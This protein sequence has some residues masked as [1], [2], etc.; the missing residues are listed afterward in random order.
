[1]DSP[2]TRPITKLNLDITY[3]ATYEA[4]A[5]AC[6]GH[7][8]TGAPSDF[9]PSYRMLTAAF[10]HLTDLRL[11][12]PHASAVDE[13]SWQQMD[14][15]T[16]GILRAATQLRR[17]DLK[18]HDSE[19]ID[20]YMDGNTDWTTESIASIFKNDTG[21]VW[22]HL[23]HLAL[24]V[25]M[26]SDEFTQFL[27][28]HSATLRSLELRDMIVYE[29]RELCL[30]IPKML[31]LDHVYF[32]CVYHGEHEGEWQD[33]EDVELQCA[34]GR[35]TDYDDPYE[36]AVKA[37]LL[38]QGEELPRLREDVLGRDCGE[39]MEEDQEQDDDGDVSNGNDD[40]NGMT[41]NDDI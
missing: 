22:P 13:P 28:N 15:E 34:F 2:G 12:N 29:A 30:Q 10:Q 35:G 6:D 27:W 5:G 32:G 36:K 9:A 26:G 11:H 19:K 18:F 21:V 38:G 33:G 3:R 16:A 8:P 7:G 23:Q 41:Y 4:V 17:L 40:E 31:K 37:Y 24:A 25:N 1:M 39:A 14:K 20:I